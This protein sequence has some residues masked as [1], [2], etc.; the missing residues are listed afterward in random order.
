[1]SWSKLGLPDKT[2]TGGGLSIIDS[3]GVILAFSIICKNPGRPGWRVGEIAMV[4]SEALISVR[5]YQRKRIY[6]QKILYL[7]TID[8]STTVP[9]S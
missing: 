3:Y 8:V 9:L 1:M 4:L 5:K 6:R 7:V 2:R